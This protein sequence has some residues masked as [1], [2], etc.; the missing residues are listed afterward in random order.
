MANPRK[1]WLV[2]GSSYL[3]RAF[4]ALPPLTTSTGVPTGAVLGVLNMLNKLL[5]DENPELIAIVLD[6]PGRTFRDDLF[7]AYKAHRP[8]MPDDLRSQVEPLIE[9]IPALGLPLLRISG[10]EADDVIG[11]LA[12]RASKQGFDVVVSTG[13]KDMAQLVNDRITLVNTMFDTKLDR[14]GVKTKFDVLPEQIVDYLAL[15]G[16]SS[17]NIPGVPKVGP[18]TAAKWLNEYGSVDALVAQANEITG[19]VG[20]SLR[21]NLETLELSRKLATIRRD[22]ELPLSP[23]ELTRK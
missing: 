20:E 16:D 23:S 17:D 18:K 8:P 1:F 22:V 13:D 11:T 5:K 15:V 14:I 10:V 9:A 4:F 2:D 19:K 3:Y 12:E 7:D 6:A 21:D